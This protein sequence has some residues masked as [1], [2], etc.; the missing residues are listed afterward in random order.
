MLSNFEPAE[1]LLAPKGI[2]YNLV[3]KFVWYH[4]RFSNKPLDYEI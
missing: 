3:H 1:V 2:Y 4:I